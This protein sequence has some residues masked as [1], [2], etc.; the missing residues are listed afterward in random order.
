MPVTVLIVDDQEVFRRV[1]RG[2]LLATAGFEQIGEASCG[3]D[4]LALAAELH[5]DLVLLDVRMPGMDGIETARR[6]AAVVPDTVVALVSLDGPADLP[7]TIDDASA[8]TQI[9]KQ[10]LSPQKLRD[11]WRAHG[12]GAQ[13]R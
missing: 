2:L 6:L 12:S 1:A 7:S 11:V 13:L 8:A 3:E 9:R 4:A 10:D 5:P